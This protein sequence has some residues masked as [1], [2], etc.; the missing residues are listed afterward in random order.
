MSLSAEDKERVRERLE[1]MIAEY[2]AKPTAEL[3]DEFGLAVAVMP[4]AEREYVLTLL[5]ELVAAERG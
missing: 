4:A 3:E 2:R 1:R 5:L